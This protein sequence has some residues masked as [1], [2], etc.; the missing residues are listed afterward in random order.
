MRP[1][2]SLRVFVFWKDVVLRFRQKEKWAHGLIEIVGQIPC[3]FRNA[4]DF[5][6]ACRSRFRSSEMLSNRVFLLEKFSCKRFVDDCYML[7]GLRI[8]FGNGAA[9]KDWI[10]D[11]F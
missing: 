9:S 10:S 6:L 7:R 3:V 11:D 5:V 2:I 4:D 8:L 1:H